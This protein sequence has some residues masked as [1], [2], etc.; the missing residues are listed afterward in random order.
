MDILANSKELA[1]KIKGPKNMTLIKNNA[2][3]KS[4]FNINTQPVS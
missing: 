1:S 4:A 2:E 3:I